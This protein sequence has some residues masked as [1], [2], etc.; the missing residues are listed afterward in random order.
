MEI[1]DKF[2]FI[3][4]LNCFLSYYKR[5]RKLSSKVEDISNLYRKDCFRDYVSDF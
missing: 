4:V 5:N 3:N 2:Y 1:F